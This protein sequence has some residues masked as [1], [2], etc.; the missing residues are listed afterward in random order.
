MLTWLQTPQPNLSWFK[1]ALVDEVCYHA[2]RTTAETD[3]TAF[4][5]VQ[6][7][8]LALFWWTSKPIARE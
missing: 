8:I 3:L 5:N 4:Q 7:L 2:S 1:R 6:Y